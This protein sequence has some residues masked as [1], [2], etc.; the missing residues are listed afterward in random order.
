VNGEHVD[1]S[2]L[3]GVILIF[4]ISVGVLHGP[5]KHTMKQDSCT[6][7]VT[8]RLSSASLKP[9]DILNVLH[10]L[11]MTHDVGMLAGVMDRC[12]ESMIQDI[13]TTVAQDQ[14]FPFSKDE[15][16][17]L[18]LMIAC[19]HPHN[20]LMQYALLDLMLESDL[21]HSHAPLLLELAH[22]DYYAVASTVLSWIK[23]EKTQRILKKHGIECT[24]QS[25]CYEGMSGAVMAND[26]KSLE[27]LSALGVRIDESLASALLMHVVYE[28]KDVAFIPF[29]LKRGAD[30]N[31]IGP[32]KHTLLTKAIALRNTRMVQVLLELGADVHKVG[33]S[34]IE[35]ALCAIQR[36]ENQDVKSLLAVYECME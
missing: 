17:Q 20:R 23:L 36:P 34:R 18:L 25:L 31:I 15:K 11:A 10:P 13:A 16:R 28:G 22:S 9:Q 30:I 1:I 29:L 4:S 27:L 35:S 21:L 12:S 5:S 32:D 6:D 26:Y 7:I 24:H 3:L 2:I 19:H 14:L 33:D 8:A